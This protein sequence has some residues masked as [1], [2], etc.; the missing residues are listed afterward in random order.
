VPINTVQCYLA[1]LLNGLPL[2]GPAGESGALACYITPPDPGN[3]EVPTAYLWPTGGTEGRLTTPRA[4]G[5]NVEFPGWKRL[6]HQVPLFIAWVGVADD[7]SADTNFPAVVDAIM[8]CLRIS[9]DEVLATDPVSGIQSSLILGVGEVMT[10]DYAV[11]HTEA[12]QR[13]LRYDARLSLTVI[14]YFQS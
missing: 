12:D 2:P 7:P 8:A 14:E 1:G 4:G 3:L 5:P 13:L 9:P 10:Y 6:D 11:V